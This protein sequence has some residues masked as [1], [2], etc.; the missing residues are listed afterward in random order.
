[1]NPRTDRPT[2][3]GRLAHAAVAPLIALIVGYI[4]V[5]A[6]ML[7]AE[8]VA[9]RGDWHNDVQ[10]R[11]IG[12][13]GVT[14]TFSH[15]HTPHQW[16]RDEGDKTLLWAGWDRK[17]TKHNWFV[18]GKGEISADHL[19]HA[20][21][22]DVARAIDTPKL[23]SGGGEVWNA[24][25]SNTPVIVGEFQGIAVAY[26]LGVLEKVLIV[27][28][29]IHKQPCL[30]VHTPFVAAAHAGE[31]F[32][33]LLEGKRVMMGYAGYLWDARPLLYDRETESLWVANN[34]GLEAIAGKRK[35]AVLARLAHLDAMPWGEWSSAHPDG[36][37]VAGA[38][39]QELKD[40]NR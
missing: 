3:R 39:R 9:L 40:A 35:G 15:A 7:W 24:M 16:V 34:R 6:P 4:G 25:R 30:V 13:P 14:P 11:V 38:I 23:E 10:R 5:M 22:R 28:D 17:A 36:R 27:N 32:N 29:E 20:M 2:A 8:F 37:L 33:P 21:G 18:L 31:M 19:S 1:M 12:F 26:P